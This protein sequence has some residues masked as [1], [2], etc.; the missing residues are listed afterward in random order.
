[1]RPILFEFFGI[2]VYGYGFMV[3]LAFI[4]GYAISL[5]HVNKANMTRELFADFTLWMAVSGVVGA[6]LLYVALNWSEYADNLLT[7]FD[8]RAGGLA[9]H[10]GAIAAIIVG[11]WFVRKHRLSVGQ[12]ADAVTPA[13][14]LGIAIVRLGCLLNGCCYGLPSELPW[15]FDCSYWHDGARH[16]TQIYESLA[17]FGV[18]WYLSKRRQHNQFPGYLL[19][20]FSIQYSAVRFIVEFFRDVREFSAVLSMAQTAS[21]IIAVLGFVSL[22]IGQRIH[23]SSQKRRI[24]G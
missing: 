11:V 5:K 1:V 3:A 24:Q 10:G 13:F 23:R 20:I 9:F 18:F 17:M 16:P 4:V 8:L 14:A 15:C 22:I 12:I 2:P 19:I 21:L 6:R 7:I